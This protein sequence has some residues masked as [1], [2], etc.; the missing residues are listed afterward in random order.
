ADSGSRDPHPRSQPVRICADG[1]SAALTVSRD[2]AAELLAYD[3][4]RT[5]PCLALRILSSPRTMESR[6]VS[7]LHQ[8][9]EAYCRRL[10]RPRAARRLSWHPRRP[11]ADARARER[12]ERPA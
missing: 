4:T 11:A 10:P 3:L 7:T 8:G 1:N 9:H 12:A 5:D 2:G 6:H